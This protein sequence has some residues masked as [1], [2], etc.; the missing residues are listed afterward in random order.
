MFLTN[1]R[2]VLA[3]RLVLGCSD[4]GCRLPNG[5]LMAW[6]GLGGKTHITP[7]EPHDPEFKTLVAPV[8]LAH[9]A[10]AFDFGGPALGLLTGWERLDAQCAI[11]RNAAVVV[12]E[13]C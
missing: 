7:I 12:F 10:F 13:L 11:W 2:R 4:D 5:F 1:K 3:L 9:G 6:I 8:L